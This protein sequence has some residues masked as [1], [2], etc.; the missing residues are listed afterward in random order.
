ML[1]SAFHLTELPVET[2]E[3]VLLHLPSQDVIKMEM[4]WRVIVI[5]DD[6]PLTFRCTV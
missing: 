4:V 2:L 5:P 3:Q 6:F 1:A